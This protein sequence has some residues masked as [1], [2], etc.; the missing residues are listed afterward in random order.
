[1]L[2][3]VRRDH[4]DNEGRVLNACFVRVVTFP[5]LG[6]SEVFGVEFFFSVERSGDV[7]K[8]KAGTDR[9]ALTSPASVYCGCGCICC[10]NC[11]LCVWL[12]KEFGYY[13]R[14]L[15]VTQDFFGRERERERERE[16]GLSA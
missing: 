12:V 10:E 7:T 4:G 6:V 14:L 11:W 15:R 16:R 8:D 2:F 9:A 13:T 3:Y 1:M 5:L